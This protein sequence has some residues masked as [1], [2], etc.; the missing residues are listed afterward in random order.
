MSDGGSTARSDVIGGAGWIVFGLAIV[1]AAWRMDR[2]ESMG[3]TL[4]TMPGFVPG[5]FGGLLI[6][7][8]S[9]L[10]W[11]GWRRRRS[12]AVA[13]ASVPGA[14]APRV[15][16]RRIWIV[17]ALSLAYAAVLV[18]RAPFWLATFLY[19]TAFTWVFAPSDTGARRR[20]LV[21]LAAGIVTTAVVVVVFEQVFLV[22]LP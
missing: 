10:A 6:L 21:A 17:L 7:L 18:G 16:N 1:A 9:A 2:F 3:A 12:L 8:G 11:R 20:A 19:L 22:R 13:S 14:A 15:F 5:L 4:Y